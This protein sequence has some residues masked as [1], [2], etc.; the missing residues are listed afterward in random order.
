MSPQHN[1]QVRVRAAS[2][3]WSFY[4]NLELL[5]CLH[6]LEAK[7]NT[8]DTQVHTHVDAQESWTTYDA[9][10]ASSKL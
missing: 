1:D 2:N 10:R 8:L 7:N 6:N 3:P 4:I 9:S 5:F